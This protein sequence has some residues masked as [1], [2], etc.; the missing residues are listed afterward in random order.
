[1]DYDS[2]RK[3]AREK[4][5][6]QLCVMEQVEQLRGQAQGPSSA[7]QP[8]T[9]WWKPLTLEPLRG[10]GLPQGGQPE[11][12]VQELRQLWK[13]FKAKHSANLSHLDKQEKH[14]LFLVELQ[15][16]FGIAKERL[17]H[18][19]LNYPSTSYR[20]ST[21]ASSSS[22][23]SSA[24]STTA[25]SFQ[26]EYKTKEEE[27]EEDKEGKEG[28]EKEKEKEEEASEVKTKSRLRRRD[29]TPPSF[30]TMAS[31]K[32]TETA[33]T[34]LKRSNTRSRSATR[35]TK[36]KRGL[37]LS[38]IVDASR[39]LEEEEEEEEEKH[40]D[41]E[42][43]K[44][45]RTKGAKAAST[46]EGKNTKT[47]S[48]P[49]VKKQKLGP[50]AVQKPRPEKR[51]SRYRSSPSKALLERMDQALTEKMYLIARPSLEEEVA[52]AYCRHYEVLG[53]TGSLYSIKITNLPS[54][55]CPDSAKGHHCAHILFVFL[56][57]LKVPPKDPVLYQRALL[58]TELSTIFERAPTSPAAEYQ[59][60]TTSG[61]V[62]EQTECFLCY[63]P[64]NNGEETV[65]MCPEGCQRF[66]HRE[67]RRRYVQLTSV[68]PPS[69][70]ACGTLW[71]PLPEDNTSHA[72]ATTTSHAVSSSAVA[73]A[74]SPSGAASSAAT[75]T[76]VTGGVTSTGG[77][78]L[79]MRGTKSVG[80]GGATISVWPNAFRGQTQ[81]QQQQQSQ[82]L[83]SPPTPLSP[84]PQQPQPQL[85][86]QPNA[87][88]Q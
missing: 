32:A 11:A 2:L 87:S 76:R 86:Q 26:D 33:L 63:D 19:A 50:I 44:T 41:E 51:L 47:H 36:Q 5:A 22:S 29:T 8:N 56:K 3:S 79:D 28:K 62:A 73:A 1:M 40:E 58:N 64:H 16:W 65:M 24:T 52:E 13:Q 77:N 75:S 70:P 30:Y 68:R 23:S 15:R 10:D 48:E 37:S 59:A 18:T 7:D 55:N 88:S 80:E 49:K 12:Y 38:S 17:K 82:Q 4:L 66:V 31:P 6:Q 69:C 46:S 35:P 72:L 67:C 57:V 54:C 43:T 85:Q 60:K 34:K 42:W 61:V 9:S 45:E 25:S 81:Q 14:L 21:A 20:T 39:E 83:P 78:K 53:P 27:E 71:P 84:Q 74:R